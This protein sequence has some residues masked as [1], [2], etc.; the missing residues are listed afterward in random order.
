MGTIDT[1]GAWGK[2]KEKD[3][4]VLEK[5]GKKIPRKKV[6]TPEEVAPI[7]AFLASNASN[8]L[9]GAIIIAD[10]G[11]TIAA[12]TVKEGASEWYE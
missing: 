4:Q 8:L 12:G 1:V 2:R 5:I 9:N 10:G 3:P 6:G 7:V 11:W